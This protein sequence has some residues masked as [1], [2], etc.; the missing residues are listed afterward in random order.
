M[1]VTKKDRTIVELLEVMLQNQKH[2][3]EGLCIWVN[4]LHASEIITDNEFLNL[5]DYIRKNRP[6]MFSSLEA[7]KNRGSLYYWPAG[8]LKPR[9]KWIEQH[10]KKLKSQK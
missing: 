7:F 2:M 8:S 1:K 6:S 4:I 10:I 5:K 9:I 3:V